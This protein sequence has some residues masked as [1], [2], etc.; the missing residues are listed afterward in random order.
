M[1]HLPAAHH[2]GIQAAVLR[3]VSS[4]HKRRIQSASHLTTAGGGAMRPVRR[5]GHTGPV[6]LCP[7]SRQGAA[8]IQAWPGKDRHTE[9]A[10][11]PSYGACGLHDL[12]CGDG[13]RTPAVRGVSGGLP[14]A[15]AA[16]PRP[17]AGGWAV[18]GVRS[19]ATAGRQALQR[20][21]GAWKKAQNRES[22]G[23]LLSLRTILDAW[24]EVMRGLSSFGAG[25]PA[26]S[27]GSISLH[28]V[29]NTTCSA[30]TDWTAMDSVRRLSR[31]FWGH[32]ARS[33]QR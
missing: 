11:G 29:R 30:L 4:A 12:L 10:A 15:P 17:L 27:A 20:L 24:P 31:A 32:P 22:G 14:G 21:P 26:P 7:L 33:R 25:V 2:V 1:S 13:N 3:I 19:Y 9:A 18:R 28:L 5:C 23:G 6:K 8:E 16:G